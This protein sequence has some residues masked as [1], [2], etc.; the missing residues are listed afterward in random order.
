MCERVISYSY[1]IYRDNIS[2]EDCRRTEL[3]YRLQH[4]RLNVVEYVLLYSQA[5]DLA[6]SGALWLT[7]T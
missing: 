1:S 5:A 3:K 7:L 2:E 4:R 6:V